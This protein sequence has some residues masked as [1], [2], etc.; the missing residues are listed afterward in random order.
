MADFASSTVASAISAISVPSAGFIALKV[1]PVLL[2]LNSPLMY[3]KYFSIIKSISLLIKKL[4]KNEI[5]W[6]ESIYLDTLKIHQ[7]IQIIEDSQ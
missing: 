6:L 3:N 5:F 4:V 2:S 1:F 7:I